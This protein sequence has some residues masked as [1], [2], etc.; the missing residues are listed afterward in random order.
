M[1]VEIVPPI[2]KSP[3]DS[4]RGRGK[5]RFPRRATPKVSR[6]TQSTVG[7]T[8]IRIIVQNESFQLVEHNGK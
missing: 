5:V 2:T 8:V 7:P 1:E 4:A 6:P 3:L